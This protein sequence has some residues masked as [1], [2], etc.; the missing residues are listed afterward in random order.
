MIPLIEAL[1]LNDVPPEKAVF[2]KRAFSESWIL[3]MH[4]DGR[5]YAGTVAGGGVLWSS[6]NGSRSFTGEI[7]DGPFS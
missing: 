4:R 1:W 6:A 2:V 5:A 7:K 3:A